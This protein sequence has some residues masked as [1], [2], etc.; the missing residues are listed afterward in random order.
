MYVDDLGWNDIG[1]NGYTNTKTPFIDSLATKE[2][3]ILTSNYVERLCTP[4]RAS[5][6]TG[7]YPIRYGLQHQVLINDRPYALTRQVSLLSDEFKSMGW[8]THMI[9]KYFS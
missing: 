3:L 2:G 4:T 5:F 6:I 9:G 1:Y 7:R 8:N